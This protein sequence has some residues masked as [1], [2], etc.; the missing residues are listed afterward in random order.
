MSMNHLSPAKMGF[1]KLSSVSVLLLPFFLLTMQL[2]QTLSVRAETNGKVYVVYMGAR[3]HEDPNLVTASH[4]DMLASVL[5]RYVLY[6]MLA[7]VLG[8]KEAAVESMLYS[9]KHGFSGFSA[10]LTESQAKQISKIP[11]VIRVTPSR[12]CKL[13]TT[14]S[15]DFL[16]LDYS[17][18][19][20]ILSKTNQG[21][22]VII[23]V[24]DSGI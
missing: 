12:S 17:H 20:E 13:Q 2:H 10:T 11:G 9:Y 7:S 6:D 22:G 3:Q 24:V 15:W 21:D 4:H 23:G 16:G 8:S 5:G 18:P 14:R 19:T 1:V